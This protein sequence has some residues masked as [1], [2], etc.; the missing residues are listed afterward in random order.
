MK[1][2]EF[3]RQVDEFIQDAVY[4]YVVGIEDDDYEPMTETDWVEYVWTVFKM[5]QDMI[6]NGLERKHLK[7]YGKDAFDAKVRKFLKTDA[8]VKPYVIR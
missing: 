4:G 3:E 7:F 1:K 8:Y 6:V 2:S 5:E